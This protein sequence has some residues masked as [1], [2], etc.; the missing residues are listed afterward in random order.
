M[1]FW[2]ST[3]FSLNK[4]PQKNTKELGS[5]G[6]QRATGVCSMSQTFLMRLWSLVVLSSREG[7]ID[8]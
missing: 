7:S 6:R 1:S 2:H 4:T 5:T 3:C 8:R